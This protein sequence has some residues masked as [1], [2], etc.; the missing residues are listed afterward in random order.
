MEAEVTNEASTS[1]QVAIN[2]ANLLD[3]A[4]AQALPVL[5]PTLERIEGYSLTQLGWISSIRAFLQALFTP[6]WGY[7]ADRY[8]RR[9]VLTVACAFWGLFTLLCAFAWDYP[10]LLMFRAVVGIGL[11]AIVPT[12]F[13][14]VADYVAPE[15][16]G[17]SYGILGLTGILGVIVGSLV[18]TIIAPS[19]NESTFLGLEMWRW[20]FVFFA[21]VS[22]IIS[23]V[24]YV[25]IKEP[26]RGQSNEELTGVAIEEYE[27]QFRIRR[28]DFGKILRNR[29]F[30]IIVIQGTVGTVPWAAILFIIDWFGPNNVGFSD[31]EATILFAVIA[32]AAAFGNLLGGIIGDKAA[33][34]NYDKGRI[35]IAQFS[36][37]AGIPLLFIILWAL[38]R[39]TSTTG[40]FTFMIFGVVAGLLITWPQMGTNNPIFAELFE[41]EIRASAFSVDRVF[42]GGVGAFGFVIVGWFAQQLGYVNLNKFTEGTQAYETQ[43]K[44]NT[45]YLAEAMLWVMLVCWILSIL[46]YVLVYFTYPKDR[47]KTKQVLMERSKELKLV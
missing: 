15:K 28:S 13:S 8:S 6:V 30:M 41:P 32:L 35:L 21:V 22:F 23:L 18:V 37:F 25:Y 12:S 47:D 42:E 19:E 9:Y 33:K 40:F 3:Y 45:D 36:V 20:V 34:W 4:D 24:V 44:L 10:S 16:R 1:T 43:R 26:V 14:L 38:P 29:T 39:D 7:L 27:E 17:K 31:I 5:Y 2:L 46:L 11:A